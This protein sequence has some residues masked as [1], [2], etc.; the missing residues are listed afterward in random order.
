M[1]L[2]PTW[3]SRIMIKGCIVGMVLWSHENDSRSILIDHCT[4]PQ[5]S[6]DLRSIECLMA[7]SNGLKRTDQGCWGRR[8]NECSRSWSFFYKNKLLLNTQASS[9]VIYDLQGDF[10]KRTILIFHNPHSIPFHYSFKTIESIPS[11]S[12]YWMVIFNWNCYVNKDKLDL[13]SPLQIFS[14]V[15]YHGLIFRLNFNRGYKSIYPFIYSFSCYF[16]GLNSWKRRVIIICIS[17][18]LFLPISES[19][20]QFLQ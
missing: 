7:T 8:R 2:L 10:I 19:N 14:V 9:W 1:S 6:N 16:R 4:L 3:L 18:I 11:I 13:K 17:G 15:R 5:R 20:K 12:Y